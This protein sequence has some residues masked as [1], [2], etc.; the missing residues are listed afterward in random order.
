MKKRMKKKE[1]KNHIQ[2]CEKENYNNTFNT[3]EMRELIVSAF[4]FDVGA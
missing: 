4:A 3:Q 2:N 1:K